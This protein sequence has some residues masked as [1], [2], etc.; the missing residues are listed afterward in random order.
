MDKI[1]GLGKAGCNI[2]R[3]FEKYPQ[4]DVYKIDHRHSDEMNYYVYPK[5]EDPELYDAHSPDLEYFFKS[6]RYQKI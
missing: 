4:Y 5:Y 6:K 1:I 3:G 2:A